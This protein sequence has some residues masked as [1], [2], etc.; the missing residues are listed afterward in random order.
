MKKTAQP[1]DLSNVPTYRL[2]G[3]ECIRT[4]QYDP[5]AYVVGKGNIGLLFNRHGKTIGKIH[6]LP[7]SPL[8]FLERWG[9][10][11]ISVAQSLT[12]A[13][14]RLDARVSSGRAA[15][16]RASVAANRERKASTSVSSG[17]SAHNA[18]EPLAE[19]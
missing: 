14:P 3:G 19:D 6:K 10:Q 7:D 2:V 13:A 12:N 15:N 4:P 5:K 11:L 9:N 8:G 1:S 16:G 17:T 18:T